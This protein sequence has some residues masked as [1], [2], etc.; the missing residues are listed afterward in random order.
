MGDK[1]KDL[2]GKAKEVDVVD[3]LNQFKDKITSLISGHKRAMRAI[4]A[5]MVHNVALAFPVYRRDLGQKIADFFK[6]H[7]NKIQD[8]LSK[9]GD[10]AKG[11]AT[12]ILDT[13]K[14]NSNKLA[15]S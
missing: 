6:P 5:E 2:I 9:I 7:I 1:L 3:K 11:H 4:E 15:E 13:L 14:E 10:A 8:T 12:N